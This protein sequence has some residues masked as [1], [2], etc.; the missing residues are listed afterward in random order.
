MA[1]TTKTNPNHASTDQ[2]EAS[3]AV[4]EKSLGDKNKEVLQPS[5]NNLIALGR[6]IKQLHWNVIGPNFRPI[7]L[8]LDEIYELVDEYADQVA[9]RMAAVGRSANGRIKD[10]ASHADV[11]DAPEGFTRD[12]E[13]LACAADRL[14]VA[15][16][17]IRMECDKVEDIDTVT[18]D[19]LHGIIDKL[20]MHHWMIQAQ[21]I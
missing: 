21:R 14:K 2:V 19:L 7:H 11:I 3:L 4:V 20:E 18:A 1:T 16:K 9:E 12:V 10:V 5:L 15:A 13:V 17:A 8:H 6:V